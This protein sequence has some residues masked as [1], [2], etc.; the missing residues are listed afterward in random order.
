MA[1]NIF[2]PNFMYSFE[3]KIKSAAFKF[4]NLKT[5]SHYLREKRN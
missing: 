2:K 3:S 4:I 1:K 5:H